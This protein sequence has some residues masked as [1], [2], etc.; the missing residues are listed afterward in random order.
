[1]KSSML[2]V[3]FFL[4][5]KTANIYVNIILNQHFSCLYLYSFKSFNNPS[6]FPHKNMDVKDCFHISVVTYTDKCDHI[7]LIN[8]HLSV[9]S[10]LRLKCCLNCPLCLLLFFRGFSV[11]V[12]PT[13]TPFFFLFNLWSVWFLLKHGDNESIEG[14]HGFVR[15]VSYMEPVVMDMKIV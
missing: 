15:C 11:V 13:H 14:L 5:T 2:L 7:L 12:S 10:R 6:A 8:Y 3:I 1:M 9:F 4:P